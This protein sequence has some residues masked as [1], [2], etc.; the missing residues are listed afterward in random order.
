MFSPLIQE[1]VPGAL[2]GQVASVDYV[3]GFALSPLG[4]IA[5]GAAVNTIGVRTTLIAGG[6]ITG[7]TTLIPLLPG[8][9]DPTRNRPADAEADHRPRPA[10]TE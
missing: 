8:V 3:L 1:G 4:L 5:A 7:L 2:L 9:E 10:A 6:A